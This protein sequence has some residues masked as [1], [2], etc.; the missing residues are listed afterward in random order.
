MN[1]IFNLNNIFAFPLKA[2]DLQN[3]FFC[4][5]LLKERFFCISEDYESGFYRSPNALQE[6]YQ[7]VLEEDVMDYIK[8]LDKHIYECILFNFLYKIRDELETL[9]FD[10][11]NQ[12]LTDEEIKK[13]FKNFG[14]SFDKDDFNED[15][16]ADK[17]AEFMQIAEE[18]YKNENLRKFIEFCADTSDILAVCEKQNIRAYDYASIIALAIIGFEDLYLKQ[19]KYEKI[20][21]VYGEKILSEFNGWDEFIASFMLGELYKNSFE[22]REDDEDDY[23]TTSNLRL[24]Y[25]ALTLPY[26]IFQMSGIWENSVENAKE[27]L[28]SIL[29]KRLDKNETGEQKEL[30]EKNRKY[31]DGECAKLGL[32]T[33]DFTQILNIFYEEFYAPFRNLETDYLFSETEK[34]IVT[35]FTTLEGDDTLYKDSS[36]GILFEIFYACVSH[37]NEA[38]RNS[39][40]SLF[41]AANKFLKR[42]KLELKRNELPI[43]LPLIIFKNALITTKAVYFPN[44]FL[45]VKRIDWVDVKFSAKVFT[46]EDIECRFS[47]EDVFVLSLKFS[48]FIAENLNLRKEVIEELGYEVKALELAFN[49]LKKRFS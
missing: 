39:H 30:Y 12:I 6:T 11:F 49:N 25:N 37:F 36:S 21:N 17:K 43:E 8:K 4:K 14:V 16:F 42:H 3:V 22:K 46:F 32:N 38:K 5:E 48:D 31:Y 9:S 29:E 19:K 41:E 26:D 28:V 35:P 44:G 27:K 33:Q 7:V 47:N 1:K 23:E 18:F 10:E 2:Y 20:V 45:K 24:V 13:E 34:D 40:Y 15:D